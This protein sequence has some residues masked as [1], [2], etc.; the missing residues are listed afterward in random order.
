MAEKQIPIL[1]VALRCCCPR[2]GKGRMFKGLLTLQSSC[3]VCGLNYAQ[4]DTG[5]AG[6]VILIMVLG[7]I[8]VGMAFWVEFHFSPPLWVHAVLWP[9]VTIPLAVLLMR[10]MKAALVASQFQHRPDEMGL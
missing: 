5:D 4:S 1:E 7:F 6:A 2:C 3:P 10:P 8:V 9:I